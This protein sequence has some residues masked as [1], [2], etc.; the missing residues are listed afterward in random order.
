MPD[1]R[2]PS[3]PPKGRF[4]WL[5]TGISTGIAIGFVASLYQIHRQDPNNEMPWVRQLDVRATYVLVGATI[6]LVVGLAIDLAL[7]TWRR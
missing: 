5:L 3:P 7:S 1:L 4:L 2:L 6:G